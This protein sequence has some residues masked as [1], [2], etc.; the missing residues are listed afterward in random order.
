MSE[1][2]IVNHFAIIDE[3]DASDPY[4][5]RINKIFL[6]GSYDYTNRLWLFYKTGNFDDKPD[7]SKL[8]ATVKP[9]TIVDYL[10][11]IFGQNKNYVIIFFD[12]Y[13]DLDD[14]CPRYNINQMNDI[15]RLLNLIYH[16]PVK[17]N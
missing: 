4:W 1:S 6:V 2:L 9:D 15:K 10:K 13:F 11:F 8:N 3:K 5:F 12:K 16:I 17:K 7:N 14:H